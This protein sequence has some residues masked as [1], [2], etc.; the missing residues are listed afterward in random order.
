MSLAG[1]FDF[2]LLGPVFD[3]HLVC[4]AAL[5]QARQALAL[6]DIVLL[7]VRLLKTLGAGL[8]L[9]QAISLNLFLVFRRLLHRLDSRARLSAELLQLATI[10][11][12]RA[13]RREHNARELAVRAW[14][15]CVSEEIPLEGELAASVL[16]T[17]PVSVQTMAEV[18]EPREAALISALGKRL[19]RQSPLDRGGRALPLL[20]KS[21]ARDGGLQGPGRL[22]GRH[23]IVTTVIKDNLLIHVSS[24]GI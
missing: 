14:C 13:G 12:D 11:E 6:D 10:V 1:G 23:R 4:Q 16:V 9:E 18:D 7:P 3:D 8:E 2:L 5:K 21:S 19:L 20:M 17:H 24:V 22:K 15:L